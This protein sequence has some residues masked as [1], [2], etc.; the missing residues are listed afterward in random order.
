MT[1][2]VYFQTSEDLLHAFHTIHFFTASVSLLCLI[3][4]PMRPSQSAQIL[5]LAGEM[6]CIILN[7]SRPL[8]INFFFYVQSFSFF[9]QAISHR[10]NVQWQAQVV[11]VCE[12][13]LAVKGVQ[14]E[15]EAWEV[16]TIIRKQRSELS[17]LGLMHSTSFLYHL[18]R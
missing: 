8:R 4:W 12:C 17:R 6:W 18:S 15:S 1:F 5:P 3:L 16:I 11:S 9:L 13:L 10:K 7:L 2:L 14:V